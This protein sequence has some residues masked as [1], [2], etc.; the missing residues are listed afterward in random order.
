MKAKKN[1][2]RGVSG[3]MAETIHRDQDCYQIIMQLD[4]TFMF[5]FFLSS[6]NR[7]VKQGQPALM[8]GRSE[9]CLLMFVQ[10]LQYII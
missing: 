1:F 5:C 2:G 9:G 6:L 8:E 4:A 7:G 10:P 3:L